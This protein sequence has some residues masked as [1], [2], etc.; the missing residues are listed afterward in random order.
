MSFYLTPQSPTGATSIYIGDT[1]EDARNTLMEMGYTMDQALGAALD[2][3]VCWYEGDDVDPTAS[4][5][6]AR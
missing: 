2:G 6:V 3:R 5:E 4:T 1:P